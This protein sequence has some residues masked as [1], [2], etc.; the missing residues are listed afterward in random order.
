[1]GHNNARSRARL[2]AV[3]AAGGRIIAVGTTSLRLLESATREDG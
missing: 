2:N 3:R 1:M